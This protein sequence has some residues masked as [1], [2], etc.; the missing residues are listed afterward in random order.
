MSVGLAHPPTD[1]ELA[2]LYWELAQ[3]GAP[4]VG[5]K[6][7]WP[8]DPQ[9]TEALLAIAGDML[10]YDPRLLSILLHYVV[11]RWNTLN[12]RV[13]REVMTSMRWPQALLVVFEFAKAATSNRE[14]DLF[15]DYVSADWAPRDPAEKIFFDAERPGSRMARRNAGRNLSPYRR[16][17]FVGT[18][19]PKANVF[20]DR[21]VGAYD[22]RTRQRI[23]RRLLESS[24]RISL[25]D[26][27][28]A[29]DHSVSRQQAYN[30]LRNDGTLTLEGR[31]RGA[32]WCAIQ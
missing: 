28:D 30:D 29:I 20:T 12:P 6:S 27:L 25:N 15:V 13:L 1:K 17:G 23:R 3:I 19:R 9:G 18:E 7:R 22:A 14:L 16:W 8:Y 5:S 26:Y 21:A 11:Q 31:G 2:R 24:G 4:S 10:R 32:R